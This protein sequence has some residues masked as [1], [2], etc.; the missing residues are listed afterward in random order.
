MLYLT[1]TLKDHTLLQAI[2]RVNRLYEGKDFGYI[3]DYQGVLQG[4][5]EALDLYGQ[6]ADYDRAD[7][8]G[9]LTDVSEEV[10]KLPQ[11]YSDLW[12]VFKGVRNKKDE[13]AYER[14]LAEQAV[15]DQFYERLSAYA[16]TLAIALSSVRFLEETPEAKGEKYK[17]DLGFFMKLRS[18]VRLTLRRGR[19]FQGIRGQDPEAARH[20]RRYRRGRADHRPGQHLRQGGVRRRGREAR[21]GCL[22]GRH[23]RLPHQADDHRAMPGG[24]GVLPQVLRDAGGRHPG[25][26]REAALGRGVPPAR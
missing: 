7:L 9:T 4:L 10:R 23:D 5:S 20:P 25:V 22:K 21:R 26:P 14:H 11:R 24:P 18:A 19:R 16:R 8:E 12:D 15:R 13:E 6:L 1:R 2:A 3:I 17:A